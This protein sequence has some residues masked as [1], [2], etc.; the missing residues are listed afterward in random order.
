M[1]V[2]VKERPWDLLFVAVLTA[3]LILA[4]ALVPE[5]PFRTVLGLPFI[6]F[7][8]GYVLISFLFPGNASLDHIERIALSFGLSIAIT[9]LIGL[10]LN[11]VWKIS[12]LPI[13]Y[14]QTLFILVLSLLAYLR[15][16]SIPSEE[17]FSIEFEINPPDWENYDIIDKA[18]VIATVG[19]LI[20]SGALAYNI[21]TT[22]R[23][24]ERFTEFYV[25][26]ENGMADDYPTNLAVNESGHVILGAINR[27]HRKMDYTMVVRMASTNLNSSKELEDKVDSS[28]E[29]ESVNVK[30]NFD[31]ENMTTEPMPKDHNISLSDSVTYMANFT[32]DHDEKY[33]HHLNYS[34]GE[35]GL[36]MVQ[37]LLFKPD[38][39]SV[40]DRKGY[41]ELH[42]WVTV[43]EG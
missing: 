3:L 36:Y 2:K 4:I 17:K 26:G 43:K 18:L 37:F 32:L 8:P 22:P 40:G 7:F 13:L 14:S 12:L 5:S 16:T 23:T 6:L 35:P 1:K 10:L 15:R 30:I 25:L 24:G 33:K 11:Y 19:L 29:N 27:E 39:F 38:R 21:A 9:P 41:R 20:A 31:F 34:I 42:L 28:E